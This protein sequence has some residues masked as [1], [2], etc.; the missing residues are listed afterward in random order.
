[1]SSAANKFGTYLTEILLNEG[2]NAFTTLDVSLLSPWLLGGFDVVL[3]GQTALTAG[4]VSML[5][6]WVNGGGNLIAMRPD[7]Q[8]AGLLGLS[9]ASATLAEAYMRVDAS[10]APGTGITPATMQFH[11]T[12]DRYTLSGAT[13]VATLYSNASTATANPAVTLRSVG[14][15]GGHAAAFTYDLARSVVYTRQGNPAW[16]GQERDGVARPPSRRPVLRRA[17]RRR[18]AGLDR[19]RTRSPS[20]RPTSSSGCSS[21][22]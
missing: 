19:R 22:S 16:A 1:M 3:L 7:K 20:R 18:A 6:S 5:T 2:L 13:A 12:A 11:G 17:S 14:S 4:Q 8:L 10:A 15:S 9:D 21:T